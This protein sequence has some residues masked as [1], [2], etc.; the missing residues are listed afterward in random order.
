MSGKTV[1]VEVEV[2]AGISEATTT[3]ARQRAR[4][5]AILALWQ[6]D[7]LSTRQAAAEL[8]LSYTEFLDLLADRG[9]PME[10]GELNTGAIEAAAARL[11]G[12]QPG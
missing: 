2:P 8:D 7:V 11:A 3:L 4:E 10:R 1:R 12:K 9:M 5:G 6:D